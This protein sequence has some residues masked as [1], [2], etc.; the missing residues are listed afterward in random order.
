MAAQHQALAL[1]KERR[2]SKLQAALC[3]VLEVLERHAAVYQFSPAA[4]GMLEETAAASVTA[5]TAE[6]SGPQLARVQDAIGTCLDE[7]AA[8]FLA[9]ENRSASLCTKVGSSTVA[10]SLCL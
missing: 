10:P 5:P 6:L 8:R 1:G 9:A 7:A 3:F 4:N 2:C